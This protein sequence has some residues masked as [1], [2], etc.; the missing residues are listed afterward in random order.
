MESGERNPRPSE[1][2][3]DEIAT[4]EG[5][6]PLDLD[7]QLFDVVEVDALDTLLTHQRQRGA[8]NLSVEF[9]IGDYEVTATPDE[10]SITEREEQAPLPDS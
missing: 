9:T 3:L 2:I 5:D 10:V 1:S 4:R 8:S 6:D 7:F